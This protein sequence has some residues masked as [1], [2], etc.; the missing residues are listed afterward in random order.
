VEQGGRLVIL[1]AYCALQWPWRKTIE[2]HLY[3][4]RR[5]GGADYLYVNLAVPWLSNAYLPLHFDAVV[6]HTTFLGW[7][8]W[9]P[10]AQR[11]GVMKRARRLAE[12]AA[13][14]VALPQD[15]FL[16]TDQVAEVIR[17][18]GI[19]HVFSVAPESE[20][21]LIY[22]GVDRG[23]VGI[24]RVLTGYLDEDT[25]R[26]VDA[27]VAGGA[28]RDIDIGYRTGPPK[29]FLGRQ[30]MLKTEIADVVR[31]RALAR[32][33]RV[34]ITTRPEDTLLGDDWYRWLARCRWTIGVEGGASVLDRNGSILACTERVA[35]ERPGVSFEELE[36]ACFPGLDGKFDLRALSPRHLEACA[37]RT[38]QILVEGDYNGV[39]TEGRHYIALKRDFSN[40]DQ[41]LDDVAFESLREQLAAKAY[42][43]VVHS[44]QWTYRRLV[45]DVEDVLARAGLPVP[46]PARPALVPDGPPTSGG[47]T[48]V[49]W[50][51]VQPSAPGAPAPGGPAAAGSAPSAS[52]SRPHRFPR[53][54]VAV[55][56]T[57]DAASKP[58]LPL[59]F[60]GLM[61][62][63]RRIYGLLRIRGYGA[64]EQKA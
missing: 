12:R 29:P 9:T 15:E 21:P 47:G 59:A 62:L 42:S 40:L 61:P 11:I 6:W 23:R 51:L 39:L 45:A 30:A 50:K 34:D 27:I 54:A 58:L 36:A 8:R 16:G 48:R 26:R 56:R 43:D 28:E 32:G 46:V 14:Q 24:S 55:S 10:P 4:F 2:D 57:L 22:E 49:T 17:E 41:V 31:E 25:V 7:V 5:Y 64:A 53:P 35:E 60:R 33:L 38:A 44:Q 52:A 63:R 13:F 18:F 1:V 3:S 19:D 20:W 37:T